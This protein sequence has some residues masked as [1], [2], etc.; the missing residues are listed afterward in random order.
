[1]TAALEPQR[2]DGERRRTARAALALA[3]SAC[4]VDG[5]VAACS[6]VP[7]ALVALGLRLVMARIF[8]L[9]GQTRI[10]GPRVP[11]NVHGFDFSVVLPP[12]VK[13]ETFTAF[14]T[15]YAA[16]PL[17]PVPAAYLLSYAEFVLPILPGARLRHPLCRA[18]R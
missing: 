5:F 14:L 13:A 11:L 15:Q 4:T 2:G 17:P 16:M 18:S 8:F 7:Y 12:Q 10:S 9:D 1:M 3:S 6:F